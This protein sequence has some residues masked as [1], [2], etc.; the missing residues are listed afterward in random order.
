MKTR[1]MWIGTVQS[2]YK[3]HIPVVLRKEFDFKTGDQV[4]W[5]QQK[6]T[7]YIKKIDN[8]FYDK[9]IKDLE[10]NIKKK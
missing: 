10:I 5:I 9:I 6:D 7:I 8:E 4:I 2:K 1:K 3:I